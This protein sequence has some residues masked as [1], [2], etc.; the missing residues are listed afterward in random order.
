MVRA[1]CLLA[2]LLPALAQAQESA[3]AGTV[4]GVGPVDGPG[5]LR[6]AREAGG[7]RWRL[8]SPVLNAEPATPAA[9]SELLAT[10]H[11]ETYL[12][13]AFAECLTALERPELAFE[14]LL[15]AG[16]RD[17]AGHVRV[18]GS[19]CA[20][21]AGDGALA[22]RRLRD[23]LVRDLPLV[24]L[25][26]TTPEHQALAET[27]GAEVR[28]VAPVSLALV[29]EPAGAAVRVDGRAACRTPCRLPLRAGAHHFELRRLGHA[30]RAFTRDVAGDA[31]WVLRLDPAPSELLRTQLARR[32]AAG[33][34]DAPEL[35]ELAADAYEARVVVLVW[36]D[37]A[38]VTAA[39]Y[40]RGLHRFVARAAGTPGDTPL[41]VGTAVEEWR[42]IVEPRPLRKRPLFWGVLAASLAVVG[43]AIGISVWALTVEPTRVNV[44]AVP[45]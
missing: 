7:A 28:A 16:H 1:V 45:E 42:G 18:L 44:Y 2:C 33:P 6:G 38:R 35:G 30:P 40:D 23:A 43:A 32:L 25:D 22:R 10:V 9:P 20:L 3:P 26:R 15:A 19:A 34:L 13:G 14:A 29:S 4:V 36:G 24:G 11:E 37:D 31:R 12:M 41:T 8:V 39:L 5:A 17:S 27:V 21:L